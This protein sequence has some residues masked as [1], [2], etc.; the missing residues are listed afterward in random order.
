MSLELKP[1]P[2]C[3]GEAK[4]SIH[5]DQLSSV[6]CMADNCGGEMYGP[7]IEV[8]IEMWNRRAAARA[9]LRATPTVAPAEPLRGLADRWEKAAHDHDNADAAHAYRVCAAD[10][11]RGLRDPRWWSATPGE[12]PDFEY[13]EGVAVA[14]SSRPSATPGGGERDE[15]RRALSLVTREREI[16]WNALDEIATPDNST[17]EQLKAVARKARDASAQYSRTSDVR[18]YW[19]RIGDRIRQRDATPA[20]PAGLCIVRDDPHDPGTPCGYPLPCKFHPYQSE[21]M[22]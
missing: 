4:P 20:E 8:A 10:L 16:A 21:P 6:E 19:D 2:F 22:K 11:R 14:R 17:A 3:G 12:E 1:C 5:G 15:L 7:D 18:A 9:A 13:V